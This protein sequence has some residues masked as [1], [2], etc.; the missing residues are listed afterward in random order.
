MNDDDD[1]NDS[2]DAD[3]SDDEEEAAA[4]ADDGNDDKHGCTTPLLP[5]R[6]LI[7]TVAH[8]ITILATTSTELSSELQ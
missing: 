1:D 6:S 2:D 5:N 4:A 7:K 8:S 3:D